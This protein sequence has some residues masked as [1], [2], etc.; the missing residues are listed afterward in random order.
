ME[1]VGDR[2]MSDVEAQRAPDHRGQGRAGQQQ[3]ADDQRVGQRRC[4]IA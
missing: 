1:T 3:C 2:R 4:A